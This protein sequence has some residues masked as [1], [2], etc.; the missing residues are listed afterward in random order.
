MRIGDLEVE[1]PATWEDHSLYSF[2]APPEIVSPEK[3]V[4]QAPFRKNVVL[5][6][7]AVAADATLPERA[8]AVLASTEREFGQQVKVEIQDGP[9]AAGVPTR[10]V[11][12]KVVDPVT[13]QPVAQVVYVMLYEGSEWQIAFSTPALSLKQALPEF[14]AIVASIRPA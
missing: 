2:V 14:D 12:Y 4:K 5:Q 13:S 1:I 10:R 8:Q 11:V 6:R 9:A 3:T 7:Q